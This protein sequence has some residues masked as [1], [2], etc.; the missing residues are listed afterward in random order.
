MEKTIKA[1]FKKGVIEP[2]EK[3]EIEEGREILVVI[4]ELPLEDRFE[5]AIG[6]WKGTHDPKKLIEDIY[7]DRLL[8]TR[9]EVKL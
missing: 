4:K 7:N 6:G 1:K 3:L 9:P 5:K 2:L 8:E